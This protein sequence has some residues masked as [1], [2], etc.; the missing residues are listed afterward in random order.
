V[1]IVGREERFI[2]SESVVARIV[3]GETLIVPVGAKVGDVVSIYSFNG[4]AALIWRLLETPKT[5]TE[6]TTAV[7]QEFEVEPERAERDVAEF[8][9]AMQAVGLVVIPAA[10]AMAGD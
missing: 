4:T 7:A 5:V 3:A 6:L 9:S 10:M 1:A 2:R 8:V